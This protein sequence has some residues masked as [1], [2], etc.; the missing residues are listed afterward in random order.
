[1][2]KVGFVEEISS[3]LIGWRNYELC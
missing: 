1:M 3:S 2:L